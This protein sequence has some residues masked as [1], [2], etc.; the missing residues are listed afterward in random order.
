M[1]TGKY[2]RALMAP[3]FAPLPNCHPKK[4]EGEVPEDEPAWYFE[5]EGAW[6]YLD[7]VHAIWFRF[8]ICSSILP[9]FL[10]GIQFT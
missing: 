9:N 1:K 8:R 5:P 2:D 7:F 6:A 3:E 4:R 10:P